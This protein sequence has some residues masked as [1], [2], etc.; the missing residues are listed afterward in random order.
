MLFVDA[1]V[2]LWAQNLPTN[3][4]HRPITAFSA[5]DL[6]KEMDEPGVD[7]AVIHPPGWDP[8]S[9]PLAIEAARPEVNHLRKSVYANPWPSSAS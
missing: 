8:N 6:L 3:P 7:A 9:G 1:Q 2:H 5:D 4:S